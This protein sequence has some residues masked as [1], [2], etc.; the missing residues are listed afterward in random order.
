VAGINLSSNNMV[1]IGDWITMPKYNADGTVFDISLITVKVR[2]FDNS[3]TLVPTYALI[4]DSFQNWRSMPEAGGRRIKRSI[5]I[6][7]FSVKIPDEKLLSS[8]EKYIPGT[9]KSFGVDSPLTNLGLFRRYMVSFLNENKLINQ[10]DSIMIRQLQMADSGI[11]LE[12]YAFYKPPV[13]W[14]NFEEFQSE[15]FEYIF[16]IMPDFGL[17]PYQ[18]PGSSAPYEIGQVLSV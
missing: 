14:E 10:A 8:I 17:V 9:V 2:N 6:D 11:P 12:V 15:L 7:V 3:V 13:K 18:R 4:S 16:A 1:Q 5:F